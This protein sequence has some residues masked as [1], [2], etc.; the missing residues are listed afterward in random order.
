MGA[1]GS[2]KTTFVNLVSGGNL[3]VGEDLE[4]CTSAVEVSPTFEL[5]GRQV[6]L[7]DTPG[8]DDTNS[9]DTDILKMIATF[10]SN[11]YERKQTL[12]G[13]IYI[14]RISDVRMGGVSRRNFKMF[15]EL[16]G[17]DTLKNVVIVTNM[18]GQVARD[19]GEAREAK[20]TQEDKFFKP[21][22][23]KGAQ[24][25]RHDNTVETARM[26]LLRLIGNKSL[27]LRIQTELVDEGKTVQQT[28]AGAELDR[29]LMEQMKK[30][31]EEVRKHKEA[32]LEVIRRQEEEA[33]RQRA[34]MERRMEQARLAAE[35]QAAEQ[36]RQQAELERRIEQ[37]RLAAEAQA[38]ELRRQ[39]AE[40]E[41]AREQ[42]RQA[43]TAAAAAAAEV[44]RQLEE[45]QRRRRKRGGD[46]LIM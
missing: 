41:R 36:R 18:W 16:C 28:A 32:A 40:L 3:Q 35:A 11:M 31:E 7:I 10:L 29:A 8:F 2:G 22:L 25:V 37:E 33:R 12:A 1:T 4:S 30:H 44:Q 13:V 39:Q 14:H 15:R 23:E 38:A 6:T 17:D 9:S 43:A 26:I 21:V 24:L 46:C 27:P 20:L 19:V 45:A 5:H 34:E 42:E